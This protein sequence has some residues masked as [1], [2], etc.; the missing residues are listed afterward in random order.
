[1][2]KGNGTSSRSLTL[3]KLLPNIFTTFGLCSGLTSMRFA[4]EG[5]WEEAVFWILLAAAFDTVDGLSARLLKAHSRFGAE[6]DSLADTISFGVAPAVVVYLWI[7]QPM[8]GN[9]DDYLLGWFWIPILGFSCCNAFRL[10]RF[11]VMHE[12]GT[13]KDKTYFLGVPAPAG[14]G[15]VMM[16]MGLEFILKRFGSDFLVAVQSVWILAWTVA[17]S[18]LMISRVPTFSF[19]NVR[20][21]VARNRAILVLLGAVLCLAVFQKE[22]WIFLFSLGLLYLCSLPFSILAFRKDHPKG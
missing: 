18:V 10:A 7:R 16:P 4:M 15:L 13:P 6:L 9:S 3:P 8:L 14:A 19:R 21:Q 22:P 11:N 17:V 12:D 2:S 20:F 5:E 1:M